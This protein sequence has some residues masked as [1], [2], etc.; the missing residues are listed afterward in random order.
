MGKMR[1]GPRIYCVRF[2]C[3]TH[4][5]MCTFH[6]LCFNLFHTYVK[7]PLYLVPYSRYSYFLISTLYLRLVFYHC[8]VV[9]L[10]IFLCKFSSNNGNNRL[11]LT[12]NKDKQVVLQQFHI[13]STTQIISCNLIRINLQSMKWNFF[14]S[15]TVNL[16]CRRKC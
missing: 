8:Y 13:W 15:Q 1:V 4:F 5:I 6:S 11:D 14:K 7:Q 2:R 12:D 9:N 16:I 3:S 10:K